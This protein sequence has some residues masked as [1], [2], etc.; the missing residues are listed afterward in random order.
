MIVREWGL[1][2]QYTSKHRLW[3]TKDSFSG[4]T[5]KP[6]EENHEKKKS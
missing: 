4:R 1:N 6:L 2:L 3:G 5:L